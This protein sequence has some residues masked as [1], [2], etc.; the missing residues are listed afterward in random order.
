MR[1][2]LDYI[3]QTLE[4]AGTFSAVSGVSVAVAGAIGCLASAL[5]A[6]QLSHLYGAAAW[7]G[8]WAAGAWRPEYT[9]AFLLIWVVA[10]A[11]AAP[12]ALWALYRK[13]R[14]WR[15]PL[16][17]GPTGRALRSMAPGWLAA[18][19]LTLALAW[20]GA[21]QWLPGAWLLLAGLALL[22]AAS[23]SI[24]PV[25][26]LGR[27]LAVLGVVA[28]FLPSPAVTLICLALGFG[29]LHL[30]AGWRIAHVSRLALEEAVAAEGI[31][32]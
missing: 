2:D 6:W 20:H 4:Q 5:T 26:W 28:F 18:A 29:V 24:S 11:F 14:K 22:S 9:R 7:R 13:S 10:L 32:R 3:R 12:L 16:R 30:A 19:L 31:P 17:R 15:L 25:R 27:G 21:P 23:F 1:A 8:V